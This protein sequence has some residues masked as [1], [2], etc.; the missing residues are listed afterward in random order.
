MFKPNFLCFIAFIWGLVITLYI[1]GTGDFTVGRM[2]IRDD[3]SLVEFFRKMKDRYCE[4]GYSVVFYLLAMDHFLLTYG[5]YN[6]NHLIVGTWLLLNLV[7]F[8]YSLLAGLVNAWTILRF[9]VVG[10][11]IILA[12]SCHDEVNRA[13]IG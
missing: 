2:V 11:S 12:K 9:I 7:V 6:A 5:V 3:Y 13:T 1:L 8:L 10:M 4:A